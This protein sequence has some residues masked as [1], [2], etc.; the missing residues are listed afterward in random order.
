MKIAICEDNKKILEY[1][2]S[3]VREHLDSR[4]KIYSFTTIADLDQE[5]DNSEF[6]IYLLD[7]ELD[8]GSGFEYAK[9]I[10]KTN[11]DCKIAFIT[12]H[13]CY[14]PS[15]YAYNIN[16]YIV[17]PI[18]QGEIESLLDNLISDFKKHFKSLTITENYREIVINA[19][20]IEFIEKVGRKTIMYT[21]NC[22]YEVNESI[23]SLIVR[24]NDKSFFRINRSLVIN[25]NSIVTMLKDESVEVQLKNH[26]INLSDN[27][28]RLLNEYRIR[29]IGDS[30]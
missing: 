11:Q 25:I 20:D 8:D 15:G 22:C 24:L 10:R 2:A 26:T 1:I 6:D 21:S 5:R 28:F 23:K 7:I 16:G 14:A 12:E 18:E 30:I 17:K 4:Y 27:E 9:S 3:S 13:E 19:V 29:R